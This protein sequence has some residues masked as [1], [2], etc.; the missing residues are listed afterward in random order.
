VSG[1]VSGATFGS[2]QGR[3]VSSIDDDAL[4][5]AGSVVTRDVPAGATE[6]TLP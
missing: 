1:P 4:V 5:G 6:K 2:E 3:S